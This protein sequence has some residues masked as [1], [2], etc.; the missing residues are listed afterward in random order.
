M[1]CHFNYL[2]LL[3]FEIIYKLWGDFN[4][5]ILLV[6]EKNFQKIKKNIKKYLKKLLIFMK[7]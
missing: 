7:K 3:L 6:L 1:L 2:I 5:S 4:Y